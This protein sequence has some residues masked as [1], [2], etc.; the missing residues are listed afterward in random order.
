M[1]N[2]ILIGMEEFT[3]EELKG[4][5]SFELERRREM[6]KL[7]AI[8]PYAVYLELKKYGADESYAFDTM[9]NMFRELEEAGYYKD[10]NLDL[11]F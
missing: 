5:T 7:E 1:E 11:P 2:K 9:S 3:V 4:V 10:M 8:N 6:Y